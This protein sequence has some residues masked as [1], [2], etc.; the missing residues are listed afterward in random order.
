MAPQWA[1]F[2]TSV[3]VKRYISEPGALQARLLLRRHDF[4]SSALIIAE[5]L[6]AFS[7]RRRSGEFSEAQFN[8]LVSRLENDRLHWELVEIGPVV[9][10]GAERL[11][12][13]PVGIRSLDAIHLASL[14]T[15]KAAVAVDI[16]FITADVRQRDAAI[17]VGLNVVWVS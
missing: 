2:D 11:V 15:F 7:R 3:L 4:L 8:T 9:L 16:P 14:M 17:H 13:G 10:Q 1:Y 12:Q 6:S 5:L